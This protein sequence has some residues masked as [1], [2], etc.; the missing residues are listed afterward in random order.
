[1]MLGHVTEGLPA[2][3]MRGP[4]PRG[5]EFQ[6]N[7]ALDQQCAGWNRRIA[8]RLRWRREREGFP[9]S[10]VGNAAYGT[11]PVRRKRS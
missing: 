5:F 2:S 11:A 6:R 9:P 3:A 10:R 4:L 7:S 8:K 1:M